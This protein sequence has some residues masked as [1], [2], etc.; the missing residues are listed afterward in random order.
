MLLLAQSCVL[1]ASPPIHFPAS[2]GDQLT[3][4]PVNRDAYRLNPYQ[5]AVEVFKGFLSCARADP[6]AE[7]L[8][9]H[10]H[11]SNSGDLA[12]FCDLVA[13][14]TA[15]CCRN[16]PSS[17][18]QCVVNLGNALKSNHTRHRLVA[19]AFYSELIRQRSSGADL[20]QV[21]RGLTSNLTDS[22]PLIRRIALKG[23]GGL[24]DI[25][26]R[27]WSEFAPVVLDA[28][29]DG[30]EEDGRDSHDGNSSPGTAKEAL[31]GLMRL[32]PVSP[33]VEVERLASRLA[34]RVR[35]FFEHELPLVRQA[36]VS[37]LAQL[38][39]A[40]SSTSARAHLTEQVCIQTTV[41]IVNFSFLFN[42][43]VFLFVAF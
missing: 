29:V 25:D 23:L 9:E 32:I 37:L 8:L 10:R 7:P 12:A 17:V 14:M 30:L 22:F 11:A 5:M 16:K 33:Q 40:G 19:V 35:P 3:F 27:L 31:E 43:F 24:S 34:L 28:L 26:P 41:L 15:L 18:P 38:F 21:I 1:G 36:A 39:R 13:Q 4:V 2:G 42:P 6:I 20:D